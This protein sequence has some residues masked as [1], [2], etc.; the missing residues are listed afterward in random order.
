MR[1]PAAARE[2]L[3]VGRTGSGLG[4]RCAWPE[5]A[6]G[7]ERR[8]PRGGCRAAPRVR[9]SPRLTLAWKKRRL[10][11]LPGGDR[12][13]PFAARGGRAPT[14]ARPRPRPPRSAPSAARALLVSGC[15]AA[16]AR[17]PAAVG[18]RLGHAR[19]LGLSPS[20][21]RR[22]EGQRGLQG[23][24]THGETRSASSSSSTP[25]PAPRTQTLPAAPR[26][27]PLRGTLKT[28]GCDGPEQLCQ[29]VDIKKEGILATLLRPEKLAKLQSHPPL[30]LPP[31]DT[32][33][34]RLLSDPEE[35]GAGGA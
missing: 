29:V 35:T 18:V 33:R 23:P 30:H 8:R 19:D 17:A 7:R 22:H 26:L 34:P 1:L 13:L 3:R 9:G 20:A 10:G 24:A 11:G 25:S 28:R 4:S 32:L 6:E 21:R 2:T 14:A 12:H 31:G 5:R 15:Q 16:A 27:F